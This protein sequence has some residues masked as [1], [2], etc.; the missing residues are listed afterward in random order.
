MTPARE[1]FG[2]PV[3]FLTVAL[4]AG[5]EFGSRIV[6]TPPSL[7]ALV[8]ATM[9]IATLVRGGALAPWR[10]LHGSR[11]VVA[12]ANGFVVLA[13]LFIASAQVLA[14]LTPRRGLPMLFVG[15]FLFVLLLN[16]LV[17]MPDRVR[18]LRSLAVTLGSALLLKF[19]VL[20]GL[21]A[22]AQSRTARVLAALVDVATF[23][24]VTQDA[25]PAVAGYVAFFA[26]ALFLLG[27]SLL[28]RP[29]SDS[30]SM[31]ELITR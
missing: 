14:M 27:V 16:T 20:A 2:L 15:I 1:S 18:L 23:G 10:L 28:P 3:L 31:T 26:I 7:F 12:N 8:L 22:P 21:S 4:S 5:A 19:V 17:V 9:L 24:T 11:S 25:Q 6:L 30:S 29:R 13:T